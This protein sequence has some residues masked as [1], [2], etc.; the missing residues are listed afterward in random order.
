MIFN[1]RTRSK[2]LREDALLV[3]AVDVVR[4]LSRLVG[5][6]QQ[7]AIFRVSEE[8]LG[9]AATPTTDSDVKG[10]VSFL[11]SQGRKELIV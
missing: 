11:G 7:A 3:A 5:S 2:N 4:R 1:E 9:Q 10:C 6:V 8:E